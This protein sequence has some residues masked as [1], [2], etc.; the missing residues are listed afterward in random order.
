VLHARHWTRVST[1]RPASAANASSFVLVGVPDLCPLR[2]R[3]GVPVDR[4]RKA[5]SPEHGLRNFRCQS[6][7]ALVTP[8]RSRIGGRLCSRRQSRREKTPSQT[9]VC[10]TMGW[11][12]LMWRRLRQ[13]DAPTRGARPGGRR[14]WSPRG[15][16][17]R[18]GRRRASSGSW[19]KS[20]SGRRSTGAPD[21][22]RSRQRPHLERG[23]RGRA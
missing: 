15:R 23:C 19:N 20:G 6:K 9:E 17:G 14:R 12:V 7:G 22:T 18:C 3:Y 1:R 21:R 11:K 13:A 4:H 2:S 16:R 5:R 10:A 8:R